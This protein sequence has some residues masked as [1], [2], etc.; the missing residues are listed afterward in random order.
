MKSFEVRGLKIDFEKYEVSVDGKPVHLTPIE[1]KLLEL[2]SKNAE[3][4]L[5]HRFII[6]KIWERILRYRNTI[7]IPNLIN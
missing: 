5:T 3:K 1:F 7:F 4:V 6:N 2:L